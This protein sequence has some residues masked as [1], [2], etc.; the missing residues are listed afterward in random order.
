MRVLPMSGEPKTTPSRERLMA[1]NCLGNMSAARRRA[2][3]KA[4]PS[5]TAVGTSRSRA[6][7]AASSQAWSL[8]RPRSVTWVTMLWMTSVR[9]AASSSGMISLAGSSSRIRSAHH[10]AMAPALAWV[11]R[12]RVRTT[13]CPFPRNTPASSRIPGRMAGA[14]GTKA[15]ESGSRKYCCMSRTIRVARAGSNP[16]RARLRLTGRA[17]SSSLDFAEM[18]AGV[19]YSVFIGHKDKSPALYNQVLNLFVSQAV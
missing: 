13:G 6:A 4:T 11:L 7:R 10:S 17:S 18:V 9:S 19:K 12:C 14:L 16:K 15:C 8:T 2:C 5:G 1:M 3:R